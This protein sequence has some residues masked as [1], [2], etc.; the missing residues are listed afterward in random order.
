MQLDLCYQVTLVDTG[1]IILFTEFLTIFSSKIY[2]SRKTLFRSFL[3]L[4]ISKKYPLETVRSWD[5]Q[6][7]MGSEPVFIKNMLVIFV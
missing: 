7:S 4:Q 1:I 5:D 3:V 2:S 6:S